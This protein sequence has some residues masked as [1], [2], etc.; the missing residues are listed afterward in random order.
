[1]HAAPISQHY[2]NRA[3]S[4]QLISFLSSF[5]CGPRALSSACP[6]LLTSL[7]RSLPIE[8]RI[9]RA[10]IVSRSVQDQSTDLI[11][12]S[13]NRRSTDLISF[14]TWMIRES[15][16]FRHNDYSLQA[17]ALLPCLALHY[18]INKIYKMN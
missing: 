12:V 14:G 13:K 6:S 18:L 16:D 8:Y 1:V 11:Y 17:S 10:F 9:S 7:L 3:I 4:I 2:Q 15:I 5:L